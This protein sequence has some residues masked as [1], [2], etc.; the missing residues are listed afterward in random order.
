[1]CDHR[2]P[3]HSASLYGRLDIVRFLL[4]HGATSNSEDKFGRTPLHLVAKG[5]YNLEQDRVR[6]AQ[7][8]LDR[9]ADVNAQTENGATPLHLASYLG[10]VDIARLLL[11]RGASADSK[12]RKGRTPLHCVAQG[13]HLYAMTFGIHV[14]QL[15]LEHGADANTPDEGKRTPL[16]LAS[17]HGKVEIAQ[18]LLDGGASANSMDVQG[19]TPLHVVSNG[20]SRYDESNVPV[21][22]LLLERGADVNAPDNAKETPL[23]LASK[24]R[25]IKTLQVLLN[26]GANA[27]AK[28]AQDQSPFDVISPYGSRGDAR[29][30]ARLL[31]EHGAD[32]DAQD[33]NYA[34][35]SESDFPAVIPPLLEWKS[36]SDPDGPDPMREYE[37]Y[38]RETFRHT[39]KWSPS[40]DSDSGKRMV[41]TTRRPHS[42][43]HCRL[44]FFKFKRR[45]S[46]SPHCQ[47]QLKR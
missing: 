44:V 41:V 10:R 30:I 12:G 15:L 16:H 25:R 40:S 32:A 37:N 26:A 14:A 43:S 27:R 13:R 21:A 1:M 11:D 33:E 45:A 7:L 39:H 9:G 18:I 34:T 6:T 31:L 20:S 22:Q 36:Q 47:K 23:H 5:E 2:T 19:Q 35:P 17:S 29:R 28:N 24:S 38:R 8:L 42:Q 3:L 46:R 4:D